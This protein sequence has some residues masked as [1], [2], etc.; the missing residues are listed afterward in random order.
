M[1]AAKKDG[2]THIIIEKDNSIQVFCEIYNNE[3]KYPYLKK[4]NDE[5]IYKK[6]QVK[7]FEI[8]YSKL[9]E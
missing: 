3:N 1:T 5:T 8:D 7:I 9:E 4:I 6:F 2:L